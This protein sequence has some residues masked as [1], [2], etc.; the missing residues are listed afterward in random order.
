MFPTV[1]STTIAPF[2]TRQRAGERSLVMTHSSRFRPSNRTI[3]SDGAAPPSTPGNTLG[4]TGSHCSA[5]SGLADAPVSLPEPWLNATLLASITARLHTKSISLSKVFSRFATS[6]MRCPAGLARCV[7][8]TRIEAARRLDVAHYLGAAD[9]GREVTEQ[10]E[11]LH[12]A[13]VMLRRTVE[14]RRRVERVPLALL[15]VHHPLLLAVERGEHSRP[16]QRRRRHE[17]AGIRL[18]GRVIHFA[19]TFAEDLLLGRTVAVG[20]HERHEGAG[21]R[22]LGT[23]SLRCR[24]N[25]FGDL[26]EKCNVFCREVSERRF[27]KRKACPLTCGQQA[28]PADECGSSQQGAYATDCVAAIDRRDRL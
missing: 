17:R 16:L 3:A 20:N 28:S 12:H 2:S 22:R 27:L 1:L 5:S 8:S 11:L 25:R 18:P 7:R 24:Q 10:R 13:E 21:L 23:R 9:L 4:G 19:H 26:V 6:G 15:C 14:S